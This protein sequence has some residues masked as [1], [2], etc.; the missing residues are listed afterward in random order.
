ML[1]MKQTAM[2]NYVESPIRIREQ[3]PS[4]RPRR[5]FANMASF[6]LSFGNS[7]SWPHGRWRAR[8]PGD[9]TR[10]TD[11]NVQLQTQIQ[12]LSANN[13]S[14]TAQVDALERPSRILG[15]A[16]NELH[17]QYQTPVQVGAASGK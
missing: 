4:T 14:L 12:T 1:A 9:F 8:V 5:R 11:Q 6:T 7:L 16:M 3:A 13:A 15:I 10:S 17:M 2:H